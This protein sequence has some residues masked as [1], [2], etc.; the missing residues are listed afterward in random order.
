MRHS[1]TKSVALS[2]LL[3]L[4]AAM[5]P[6]GADKAEAACV[7][8]V[9]SWDVLWMRAGPGT[10]YARIDAIPA[11][12]CG[13]RV[14]GPCRG[15]W[16]RVRFGGSRGWVSMRYVTSPPPARGA[17]VRGVPSWDVL[18]MRAGPGSR[19]ARIGS[20]PARACGVIVTGPCRGNWCRVRYGGSRGWA[21]TGYLR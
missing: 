10:G 15:N 12:A 13:V 3:G 11:R 2:L 18:W 9:A 19:F 6:G 16:C 5:S 7:R 8:G 1:F 4:A 14:T 17:C 21:H 20:I